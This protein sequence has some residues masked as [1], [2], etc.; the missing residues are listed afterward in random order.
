MNCSSGY[1][2][3]VGGT[4]R[5]PNFRAQA[6]GISLVALV[7][8][9]AT[10]SLY[11]ALTPLPSMSTHPAYA[12]DASA[13]T[14]SAV[15][16]T[17]GDLVVGAGENYTIQ[18]TSGGFTYF[19]GGN[20]TIDAGGILFVRNVTLSFVQFVGDTGTAE[21]RLSHIYHF[22]DQGSVVLYNAT[23]TTDVGI[24]NPY[25]KLNLTVTGVLT[26]VDSSFEFPGWFYVN[27]SKAVVTLNNSVVTGNPA[28]P[29][30]GPYEPASIWGDTQWAPT[31]YTLSG[32]KLNLFGSRVTEIYA[33]N[34]LTFGYT[35]PAPLVGGP[36][37][38]VGNSITG[39]IGPN[40][41]EALMQDWLYPSASAAS[42]YV[43]VNY[44]DTNA[45][46][47]TTA[48]LGVQY[49]GTDY[50][51]SPSLFFANGTR[52]EEIVPLSAPL[53]D[54]ITAGGM[55]NYINATGS[56]STPEQIFL[57][58]TNVNGPPVN[59]TNTTF[60]LN[61][62]GP[63]F[64]MHVSGAGAELT[65]V[66]TLLGLNW[67]PVGSSIYQ[68]YAAEYPWF[69][70]KLTF[71]NDSVG[72]L[73]NLSTPNPLP[74]A[75]GTS[76]ILP[77]NTSQVNFYRWGELNVTGGAGN[78]AISGAQLSMY[79]AYNSLQSNN[80]TTSRLNDIASTDPAMWGYVEYLD[81]ERGTTGYG[82]AN[83]KGVTS[84]LVASTELT[85]LSL[86]DGIF[87]GDYHV[88]VS[89]PGN[90][91]PTHWFGWS[92]SPYPTGVASGTPGCGRPDFV[93][94]Q[95]FLGYAFV[96]KI[97]SATAPSSTTLNLGQTY[98]TSGVVA[99]NGTQP[100]TVD[101]YATPTSGGASIL[102]GSGT[103]TPNTQFT[104]T[105]SSL[106]SVLSP[107]TSYTLSVT[108]TAYGV[109]SAP[110]TI[111]GIY[112][113]PGPAPNFFLQKVLGL[114][115]WVWLA[116]A[117]VI[118]A[119]LLAFLLVAR[120]QAAGKL[121]ECGEC[122]NLIPEDATVC[123]KCGA[124][125]EHDLIR[126]SRCASTIPADSKVCPE[127]A[128]VL[129]GK[130]GEAEADPE[131][132]G[133]ADFTEKYRA[134]GKRE[135]GDNYSEGAFWDWW[136]RQPSYVSFSQW[137]LQQGTGTSRAGMTAPP[138]PTETVIETTPTGEGLP[139]PGA[140]APP[141]GPG[142][143]PTPPAGPS[144]APAPLTCPKCGT[145]YAPN[146][147]FCNVCGATLPTGGSAE[148]RAP[149][150]MPGAPG[151]GTPPGT[152]AANLKACPSCG[153]EIPAEY[154][155]CPFCNAVTQ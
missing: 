92:A 99:Y 113:V 147:R 100:A 137:K 85:W 84:L 24:L 15:P 80:Q 106:N 40:T 114:P 25:A 121:V 18:P 134:E 138:A 90:T 133:Y 1:S 31:I 2:S 55:L 98:Y 22:V 139:P 51:L 87:L 67:N 145:A 33:D 103:A 75:F 63:D 104:V 38:L 20:I 112:S 144:A 135:L 6:L 129:L 4:T 42:G 43:L 69:S 68:L 83:S 96:I 93:P 12:S 36:L 10:T 101:V 111:P 16:P 94:A 23:V 34:L 13:R 71:S 54:A 150:T 64:D 72:Y 14:P 97:V 73:A 74:D 142:A 65:T 77:D 132:Q 3:R 151:A 76:A 60:L 86:P 148:S 47:V 95:T 7:A 125:F 8:L 39:L 154:L 82:L 153:K 50:A 29:S 119:G 120:R 62:T 128:A 59:V 17:H 53:L 116:I 152:P 5:R 127:C 26:A 126:C 48:T 44:T 37:L 141:G 35:R 124:E 117:A 61:T 9:L 46:G 146:A 143:P 28:V 110:Y 19:Q 58:Y 109:T 78:T 105:W 136:K 27:G 122:G 45:I 89:V 57:N 32:A 140:A 66:D 30:I 79:Y 56:F 149:S 115:V 88:A 107:G 155:I 130:P 21:Q 108:A 81:A 52:G 70:N 102:V 118:V 49:Y 131:R 41:P 91:V 123:P 11:V